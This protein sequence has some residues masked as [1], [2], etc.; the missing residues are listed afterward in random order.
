MIENKIDVIESEIKED[1]DLELV[2]FDVNLLENQQGKY[3]NLI[4]NQSD[5][6][7]Y[8]FKNKMY[9]FN[10][11]K[12]I[13]VANIRFVTL[14][15]TDL[16]GLEIIPID[17]NKNEKSSVLFSK[18]HR[19]WLPNKILY[20]FKINVP[21][22]LIDKIKLSKIE[23]LGFDLD[24]LNEITIKYSK[25]KEF[26]DELNSLL[27]KLKE[28]NS[29]IDEKAKIHENKINELNEQIDNSNETIESLN[30]TIENLENNVLKKLNEE[31]DKLE[32]ENQ[33]TKI[34]NEDLLTKNTNLENNIKQL[35]GTSSNLNIKI[36]TQKD[37]LQKLTEDT[38]LFAT[39]LSE[40]ITQGNKDITLYSWLSVI[41]WMLI[42]F[43]TGIIFYGSSELTTIYSLVTE[44]VKDKIDI[45]TVFWS[46]MPFVIIVVSILFV[47]YEI[48]K[49]FIKNII[50]IQ[51]QKRI[52]MK[53]GILAKDVADQSILGLDLTENEKFELR[54]KLKMDLLK[55]HLSTDIG[56]N[57]DYKIN[58]SLWDY[59]KDYILKKEK[60]YENT[61]NQDEESVELVK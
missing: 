34:K 26:K 21:K 43:V 11:I 18:E 35:E 9:S 53:I 12:P 14:N 3:S 1:K 55:S 51:K 40:Y 49:M 61:K 23:I 22:R 20:G 44:G 37:E 33:K 25:F 32:K 39:E 59:F 45:G 56:E 27:E 50:H 30:E 4:N 38:N 19:V 58:T 17:Y 54:T 16:K 7:V 15:G 28:K 36:S 41:P 52:F 6:F 13:F 24:Y 48:S 57:Y 47:C 10:F 60:K 46:R 5:D 2:K 42:A 8:E 31:K 29:E